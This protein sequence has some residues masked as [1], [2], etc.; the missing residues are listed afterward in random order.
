[1][2]IEY[3]IGDL[4]TTDSRYILHGCNDQGVM[5]SGVAKIVREKYPDAY[6]HYVLKWRDYGLKLGE[7]QY[8]PTNG[9]VI[10][11]G[12]SQNNYGRDGHRYVSYEAITQIMRTLENDLSGKTDKIAMPQIGAGLGGGDWTIISEIIEQ[13]LKTVQPV[14]YIL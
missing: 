4:F 14:V 9:K 1:M 13:E 5:G 2:K 12:I 6:K 10:V 3:I 8:V 7:V 11:N